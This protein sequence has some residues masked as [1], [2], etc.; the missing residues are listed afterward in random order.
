MSS[1]YMQGLPAD[2]VVEPAE[3]QVDE[4]WGFSA[5]PELSALFQ[6]AQQART[7]VADDAGVSCRVPAPASRLN[8][9]WPA[10][11]QGHPHCADYQNAL[12]TSRTFRCPDAV[13]SMAEAFDLSSTVASLKARRSSRCS[14][15]PAAVLLACAHQLHFRVLQ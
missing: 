3:L 9:C 15:V 2:I 11:E 10:V 7:G 12:R 13:D 5:V 14:G 6:G 8:V 1:F 4:A